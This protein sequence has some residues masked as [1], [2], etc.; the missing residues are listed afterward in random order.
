MMVID[1]L[2][3]WVLLPPKTGT[4][5]LE[6]VLEECGHPVRFVRHHPPQERRGKGD[7]RQVKH[8]YPRDPDE[9]R[10]PC[11]ARVAITVRNPYTRIV[12]YYEHIK[13]AEGPNAPFGG[14]AATWT[15]AE[16]MAR[17]HLSMWDYYQYDRQHWFYD[18][19]PRVDLILPMESLCDSL[20]RL[21][22]WETTP[23][24]DVPQANAGSYDRN[25]ASYFTDVLLVW[26]VLQEFRR[27]FDLFGY[28]DKLEDALEPPANA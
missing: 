12:S 13:R 3:T 17:R 26:R 11:D 8:W 2:N 24:D 18:S 22:G 19:V 27:D 6:R 1:S 20:T 15:F 5:T 14:A 23:V 4:N 16:F 21:M 9:C 7:R 28:S 25:L 10:I